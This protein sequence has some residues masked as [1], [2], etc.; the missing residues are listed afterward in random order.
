MVRAVCAVLLLIS[1]LMLPAKPGFAFTGEGS[2]A[3]Y[4]ALAYFD[5]TAKGGTYLRGAERDEAL[6]MSDT[7]RFARAASLLDE[8]LRA[9][10]SEAEAGRARHLLTLT[11]NRLSNALSSDG[12]WVEA[13]AAAARAC[14]IEPEDPVLWLNQAAYQNAAGQSDEAIESYEHALDA[15]RT[16]GDSAVTARARRELVDALTK[17][18]V[19]SDARDMNRVLELVGDGLYENPDDP[20]LLSR[21]AMAQYTLGELDEAIDAWERLASVRPLDEG[22]V[23]LLEEARKRSTAMRE[24][25]EFT[26]EHSGFT[27]VF[28]P[29][30]DRSAT[31]EGRN[32]SDVVIDYLI[33]A[34]DRLHTDFDVPRG[35]GLMNVYMHR[36]AEFDEIHGN[37]PIG[38][39]HWINRIDLRVL[40]GK[41]STWLR[42]YVF[43]EYAHHLTSIRSGGRP[44]PVWFNEGLAQVVEPGRDMPL[45]VKRGAKLYKMGKQLSI[46]QVESIQKL[47]GA[48]FSVAYLQSFFQVHWLVEAN[49]LGR[50]LGILDVIKTGVPFD[51]AFTGAFGSPPADFFAQWR[52]LFHAH[53]VALR[54]R[55]FPKR[56]EQKTGD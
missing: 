39:S 45:T 40:P 35:S 22:Q 51:Q 42:D 15:A 28:D 3:Y 13:A 9:D 14:A 55:Y 4:R 2:R 31:V 32:L 30:F 7:D 47:E 48:D 6:G 18:A 43:H 56:G 41:D 21:K 36:A 17:R 46:E 24:R 8:A 49:G 1:V 26:E 11:C 16:K 54:D 34:R 53:L 19:A 50:V 20:D 33:E 10:P 52:E 44:V 38:G 37:R 5:P 27:I 25:G 23:K 12:R 29:D